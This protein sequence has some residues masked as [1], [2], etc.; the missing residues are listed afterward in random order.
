MLFGDDAKWHEKTI[1]AAR[2]QHA[3]KKLSLSTKVEDIPAPPARGRPRDY[4]EDGM[5]T[6]R[7]FIKLL[8]LNKLPVFREGVIFYA[9]ELI[10]GTVWEMSFRDTTGDWKWAKWQSWYYEHFLSGEPGTDTGNQRPLDARRA[11]WGTAAN[12]HVHYENL[13]DA[14]I[15][16]RIATPNPNFDP[17]NKD[18]NG[19]PKESELC[20]DYTRLNRVVSMDES[21]V[22]KSTTGGDGARKSKTE[23]TVRSGPDDDG[24]CIGSKAPGNSFSAV[25]G[26]NGAFEGL[27][28]LFVLARESIDVEGLLGHLPVTTLRGLPVSGDVQCNTKGA[29]TGELMRKYVQTCIEPYVGEPVS[30]ENPAVFVCDGVGV[31]MTVEFLEYMTLKG[32]ILV[33]RTP[34]CSE[35]MQNEDLINFWALKN[36]AVVGLYRAKQEKLAAV[37][38]ASGLRRQELTDVELLQCTKPAWETAFSREKNTTA[39]RVAG[40]IPFTRR[41]Y[42]IQL[43]K[44]Q[45]A[46]KITEKQLV[47]VTQLNI[48]ALTLPGLKRHQP[49]S[50]QEDDSDEGG[51]DRGDVDGDAETNGRAKLTASDLAMLPGGPMSKAGIEL[52]Q[53]KYAV[54]VIKKL[55]ADSLKSVLQKENMPYQNVNQAKLACMNREAESFGYPHV[56]LAWL[57]KDLRELQEAKLGI[58]PGT[59]AAGGTKAKPKKK[60]CAFAF[61]AAKQA[62]NILVGASAAIDNNV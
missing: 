44:E 1:R 52:T 13:K 20:F 9:Q 55:D 12:M 35:K 31:H 21:R 34:Y 6:L 37:C 60:P 40:L 54:G 36:C 30:K 23:R 27:R 49:N 29:M 58:T 47:G 42:W 32:W 62:A 38:V 11:R 61:G 28:A 48:S 51:M 18:A 56:P 59:S 16:A 10:L 19:V 57:P 33:L 41:P 4:P 50:P 45:K 3:S 46:K 26:S 24:E 53:F 25:G 7:T 22:N 8:R 14:L 17:N 15:R 2:E 43:A 5:T 39:W